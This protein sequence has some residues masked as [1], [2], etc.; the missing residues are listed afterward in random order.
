MTEDGHKIYWDFAHLTIEGAKYF[1]K[2]LEENSLLLNYL[3]ST[4]NI[5]S[6]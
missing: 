3:N 1:S 4:L 2:R 6:N 5:T